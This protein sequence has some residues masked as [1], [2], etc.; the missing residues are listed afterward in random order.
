[1]E[2]QQVMSSE[3]HR[4]ILNS[5]QNEFD[6]LVIKINRIEDEYDKKLSEYNRWMYSQDF[7]PVDYEN[8]KPVYPEELG[9]LKKR[10][11]DLQF[12]IR[13]YKRDVE[14]PQEIKGFNNYSIDERKN[15]FN[16]NAAV[17]P[18]IEPGRSCVVF[19]NNVAVVIAADKALKNVITQSIDS[20]NQRDQVTVSSGYSGY[21]MITR[22]EGQRLVKECGFVGNYNSVENDFKIG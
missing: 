17:R 8:R 16:R 4:A 13:D 21:E 20:I 5:M 10:L 19:F 14:V 7:L 22:M 12:A 9:D 11:F 1:M 15:W 18:S 2:N 6:E 3:Y